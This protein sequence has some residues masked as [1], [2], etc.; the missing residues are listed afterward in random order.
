MAGKFNSK[1]R[2]LAKLRAKGNWFKGKMEVDPPEESEK[3]EWMERSSRRME[4]DSEASRGMDEAGDSLDQR[5]SG[6]T[7]GCLLAGNKREWTRKEQSSPTR[8]GVK[9]KKRGINRE[10]VTLGGRK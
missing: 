6:E 9:G 1:N 7:S 10:I 3:Q 8:R 4:N 2:R 5:D